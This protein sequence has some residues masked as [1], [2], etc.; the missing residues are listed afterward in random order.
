MEAMWR[1]VG[2]CVLVAACCRAEL[3]DVTSRQAII[4]LDITESLGNQVDQLTTPPDLPLEGDPQT[5]VEL[6][7]DEEGSKHFALNGSRLQLVE[8]LD[9][10]LNP[11]TLRFQVSCKPRSGPGQVN[12]VPVIVRVTDINDNPPVFSGLPYSVTVPELTPVGTTI[13][14]DVHADDLDSGV[15][16]QVYYSIIPGD[17]RGDATDGYGIFSITLPHQGLVTVN[18]SLD[19]ERSPVYRVTI[20]ATDRAQK[21]SGRLSTTTTLTVMVE[22]SDDQDPVFEYASCPRVGRI[23]ANP[24]YSATVTSMEVSG[25]LSVKPERIFAKDLDA[26]GT[27]VRYSFLSGRPGTYDRY[28]AINPESGS[29]TQT[30]AIDRAVT[31]QF[32]IVVKA[33][34]NSEARRFATAKL[35]IKVA[36]VDA[37]PPV[38]TASSYTGSVDE[39]AAPGTPVTDDYPKPRPITLSVTDPDLTPE[40]DPPTYT[41]ELTTTAFRV[42]PEGVLVVAEEN[43]DRDPPNPG[44]YTFQVVAREAGEDGVAAA[45]ITITVVLN[46]VNDNPPRL[47]VYPPVSIQAGAA[48][49]V[50]AT[51]TAKD[52]DAGAYA[53]V[54]YSIYHVS[55][56]GRDKFSLNAT[57]GELAVVGPVESGEQYSV[58]LRAT[59]RGGLYGQSILDIIVNRGPNTGGPVF[60]QPRYS[61]TITEGA[62]PTSAILTLSAL[63]PEGDLAIYSLVGGNDLNHFEI[64]ESSGT[65]RIADHLDRESLDLYTL[66]VKA[67]DPDGLSNTATVTVT[68]AD[69]NDKNP[70]FVEL[71]YSFRVNEGLK[72]V[73]VG[74]V[75]AM[76]ED[77]GIYGEVS[78]SVPEEA[79]F[80]IDTTTGEIKTKQALDYEKQQV[81]LLVVT[82][83]DGAADPRLSTATVT[84]LVSDMGD[85]LPV[86]SQQVYEASVPENQADA[87]L[88]TVNATDPDSVPAITYVMVNGDPKLFSVEP[89]SGRITTVRGL[90]YE[91]APRHTIVVGTLENTLDNPQATCSVLVTVLDDNDNPPVF[92]V[93][94]PPLTLPEDSPPGTLVATVLATDADGTRPNSEVTYELVGYGKAPDYFAIDGES[95]AITVKVDLQA[96]QESDFELQVV[97]SDGGTPQLTTTST[98]SI[99][100]ARMGEEP[101]P[102][103]VWATFTDAHFSAEVPEDATANTLVK[104]LTVLHRP[105][106]PKKLRC[107]ITGGNEEGVFGMEVTAERH[108][109]VVVVGPLDYEVQQDYSLTVV[110][111][112]PEAPPSTENRQAQVNVSVTDTNDNKPEFIFPSPY[113]DRTHGKFFAYVAEDS[114]ISTPVLQVVAKDKDSGE[115]GTVEYHLVPESNRGGYFSVGRDTGLLKTEREMSSVPRELLPFNLSV[116]AVDNPGQRGGPSHFTSVPVIVNLVEDIHRMVLVVDG[117]PELVKDNRDDLVAVLQEH[118]KHIIGIEKIESRRFMGNSSIVLSDATGTDVWFHVVD[119]ASGRLLPRQ[120][121]QLEKLAEEKAERQKLLFHVTAALDGMNA[122]D[123]RPCPASSPVTEPPPLPVREAATLEAY[124]VVLLVLAVIIVVMGMVGICYICVQWKRYMKHRDETNKAMVVVAPPYERVAGSVIESTKEYEVQVLH[125]SV[126]MDDDSVQDLTLDSRP[127]HHFSMDN[128]S[129][130]TKQQL[131][132]E[133]SNRSSDGGGHMLEDHHLPHEDW[134]TPPGQRHH[135]GTHQHLPHISAMAASTPSGRNPAYEHFDDHDDED[136]GGEGPLSVSATNEN[137]MFGRRGLTEPSPVQT[138]TE[139]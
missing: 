128:V 1:V 6:S 71:P 23:C 70:E 91:A 83:Q 13:F 90:D 105:D 124:Y 38:V 101:P 98:A 18:R 12:S 85:E 29:V 127:S 134:N 129:Y 63:D 87:V 76:D 17:E 32:E 19:F 81:H 75:K 25:V 60:T 86:F 103:E 93:P 8:P 88:T 125:M 46:D 62:E 115:F 138:T 44:V 4:I 59:D 113:N 36:G 50:V 84:V 78:Y 42:D 9:S 133:S 139:L 69:I 102:P 61:V 123:I 43:L 110:L 2:L 37:S 77:T 111:E 131:S 100:V 49:R 136:E 89:K 31:R 114:R 82:A 104:K 108:C 47:P 54:E 20:L 30:H 96:E 5:E 68:I 121:P 35:L 11:S 65:L 117:S 106:S 7:L 52:I 79:L 21:V 95:G 14:K 92:S 33:E 24:E 99:S 15:N 116:K 57:T 97:A 55:N 80:S 39:N 137:V 26:I 73:V 112:A 40:D 27:P 58:T 56:N 66:I 16:G 107:A 120:H 3:C 119:E 34:E 135:L 72:D 122:K 10:D 45:P 67:E 94:L 130:I 126:P 41:W 132:D 118:S 64:G 48:R 28:F 22:D 51:I 74:T 53:E 109:G